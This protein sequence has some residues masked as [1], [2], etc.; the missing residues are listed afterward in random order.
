MKREKRLTRT[1]FEVM[2]AI[3]EKDGKMTANEILENLP[4]EKEWRIQTLIT[5]LKRIVDKGYLETEKRGRERLFYAVISRD[6]YLKI[7]TKDFLTHYYNNSFQNLVSTLLDVESDETL[8]EILVL[9][10]EWKRNG[11][12][13]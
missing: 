11:K 6:D 7:E 8:E 12:H 5:L 13:Q 10:E 4:C 3:W 9:L 2:E 1:E